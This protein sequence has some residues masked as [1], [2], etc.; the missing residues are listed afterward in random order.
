M[1]VSSTSKAVVSWVWQLRQLLAIAEQELLLSYQAKVFLR[2]SATGRDLLQLSLVALVALG[3]LGLQAQ[4]AQRRVS[5]LDDDVGDRAE[6]AGERLRY[7]VRPPSSLL[8][9]L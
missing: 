4:G 8:C 3:L 2:R 5:N 7:A 9:T 1:A 6:G